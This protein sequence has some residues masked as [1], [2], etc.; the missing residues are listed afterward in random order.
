MAKTK[1]TVNLPIRKQLEEIYSNA[2]L[3]KVGEFIVEE[4]K[5]FISKGV[6]PVLGEGKFEAY[7]GVRNRTGS[8]SRKSSQSNNRYPY[9][10]R[11]KHPDK[12]ASP[13]NLKLTGKMLSEL[14]FRPQKQSVKVGFF[15]AD[16]AKRA[17]THNEGDPK[18]F[19]PRRH[20]LPTGSGEEFVVSIKRGLLDLFTDILDEILKKNK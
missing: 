13:V 16:M 1:V 12:K 7:S 19:I 11:R 2:N 3:S 20:F 10:V 8:G 18:K 17:G 4:T 6:S 15:D 5:E 9:N 14:K